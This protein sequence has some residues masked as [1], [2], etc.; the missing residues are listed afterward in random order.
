ME[1]RFGKYKGQTPDQIA[2]TDKG[3]G[4][5]RWYLDTPMNEQYLS[6]EKETR[7]QL[8][9][10][11]KTQDWSGEAKEQIKEPKIVIPQD[12]TFEIEVLHRFDKID[13]AIT[14]LTLRLDNPKD[15]D[16]L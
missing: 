3:K 1:L 16:E 11:L 2:S 7:N 8:E 4:W 14:K 10:A 6:Q 13:A 15:S 5:I 9:I 12:N